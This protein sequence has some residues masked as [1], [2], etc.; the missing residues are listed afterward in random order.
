MHS[1]HIEAAKSIAQKARTSLPRFILEATGR[2][3][4]SPAATLTAGSP[5]YFLGLNPGEIPDGAEFHDL[6]TVEKDLDR[7]ESDRIDQHGY[8][9]EK[10]KGNAPGWAPIQTAGQE[11]FAILAGGSVELGK[12]LLRRTPT[13]NF[14]LRRSPTE[15]IL[16]ARTNMTPVT[17][18]NHCWPFHQAVLRESN[19]QI[20]L[21][22]AVGV[23][24][25]F[26]KN[27]GLGDGWQRDSGW[28]GTLSTLYAWE[29]PEGPRLL[30]MPNLSRYKPD[31]PRAVALKAFFAE[32]GPIE[33][34]RDA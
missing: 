28:G 14:I 19:C 32:F 30:A 15:A 17:L 25:Q 31:G 12:S 4:Y 33:S 8:L 13:S 23:A 21:T 34:H 16:K 18:A 6:L 1:P 26:A 27:H 20:I 10:W 24:R 3:L 5:I 29:L 11:V 9:D 22:H 7:L 2:A